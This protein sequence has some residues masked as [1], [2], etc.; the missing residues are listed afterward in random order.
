LELVSRER[1]IAQTGAED[2]RAGRQPS[3]TP[4]RRPRSYI[5]LLDRDEEDEIRRAQLKIYSR[6]VAADYRELYVGIG[7]I[8]E[9]NSS[10]TRFRDPLTA[11]LSLAIGRTYV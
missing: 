11:L 2:K 9:K 8:S 6:S 5:E 1:Q 3:I 10:Q 7:G 4:L